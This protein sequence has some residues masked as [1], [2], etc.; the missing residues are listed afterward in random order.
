MR[1]S[2]TKSI[3][4]ATFAAALGSYAA[5]AE[6][7]GAS[8]EASFMPPVAESTVTPETKPETTPVPAPGLV[9]PPPAPTATIATP[10]TTPA[11]NAAPIAA[12][13]VAPVPAAPPAPAAM[14]VVQSKPV[15]A[16][17][18]ADID[19][20]SIGLLAATEG[21]LGA[22]MW[23]D[24]SRASI[25]RLLPLLP[26]PTSS[27]A[28]NNLAQRLLLTIAGVPATT[29][30]NKANLVTMR[31]DR[32]I[33]LGDV[34]DAW[35]LTQQLKPDQIDDITLRMVVEAALAAN[36][37]DICAKLPNIMK[38]HTASEWQQSLIVCQLKA[39]DHKAAQLSL[40]VMRTQEVKDDTFVSI[41]EKNIIGTSKQL[42]RQLTPVKPLTLVLA[43][44]TQ[45]P[46][47]G[48]VYGRPPASLIP[49]LVQTKARDDKAR[50][51][52][53]ERAAAQGILTGENLAHVYKS[54]TFDS[55]LLANPIAA[56]GAD[57]ARARA[58]LYQS[59]L[60]E[61]ADQNRIND[62]IRF[63]QIT[64]T[65][66]LNGS[67]STLLASMVDGISPGPEFTTSAPMMTLIYMLAGKTSEALNWLRL[68]RMAASTTPSIASE[69]ASLWPLIVLSGLETDSQFAPDLNEWLDYALK[70]GDEHA[71]R[72][73]A[74]TM[75]L[76]LDALGFTIAQEQ[77]SRVED[78]PVFE[79]HVT[80]P[81]L[82]LQRLRNAATAGRRGETVLLALILAGGKD[83][84]ATPLTTIESVRALNLVGLTADAAIIAREAA[85]T[86]L[87]APAH[88]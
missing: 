58:L 16:A 28:K 54:L 31:L 55:A 53:A 19:P 36:V 65:A 29:T 86:T 35:K 60:Q 38:G 43:N 85:L 39:N 61:K 25:E 50:L 41:V 66:L 57:A 52:L 40:D 7:A 10:S 27:P 81:A 76:L 17:K 34:D 6:V 68:A 82:L 80:P 8:R 48:E 9:T 46:L 83:G 23:K 56:G 14:P 30:A 74:S 3:I 45:L 13:A 47:S 42:P 4:T 67:A 64:D 2:L 63:I 32:L 72:E 1:A 24:T 5:H 21:G 26:L 33:A 20:Q 77:W 69:L 22:G 75:L 59:A 84:D 15:E 37:D 44:M 87:F 79:K 71:A 70:Q 11:P 49:F 88:P 18:L 78:A 51:L 73:H 12:T 62:A